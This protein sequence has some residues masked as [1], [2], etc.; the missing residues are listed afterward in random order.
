MKLP[1]NKILI[2]VVGIIILI[3]LLAVGWFFFLRNTTPLDNKKPELYLT[4]LA[5]GEW[6][7]TD[8]DNVTLNWL[9]V[10]ESGIDNI[11]WDTQNGISGLATTPGREWTI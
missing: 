4:N 3:I 2:A 5:A 7:S 8:E 11:R 9:A 10:D 6:I 1:Q